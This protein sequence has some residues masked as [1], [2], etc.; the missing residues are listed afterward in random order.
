MVPEAAGKKRRR[1]KDLNGCYQRLFR[2]CEAARGPA[3]QG[4]CL[5]GY[6]DARLPFRGIHV[7]G[8][9]RETSG[10][11]NRLRGRGGLPEGIYRFPADHKTGRANYQKRVWRI[12]DQPGPREREN[13]IHSNRWIDPIRPPWGGFF[14]FFGTVCTNRHS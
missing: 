8:N 1:F 2:K 13:I 9:H 11:K 12:S 7:C 6:R 14:L 10:I 5:A 3:E 4:I